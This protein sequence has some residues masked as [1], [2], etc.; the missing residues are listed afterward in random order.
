M[1]LNS[2]EQKA[3]DA[4]RRILDR[5]ES[6]SSKHGID[7]STAEKNAIHECFGIDLYEITFRKKDVET[8][9]RGKDEFKIEFVKPFS[10]WAKE[11]KIKPYGYFPFQVKK[12]KSK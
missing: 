7:V 11:N 6:S 4:L 3:I 10:P 2:R 9:V 5:I 12:L 1:K 8:F